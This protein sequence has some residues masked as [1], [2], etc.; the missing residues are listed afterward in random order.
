MANA[1]Q[2]NNAANKAS[3]K[4]LAEELSRG[5][6]SVFDEIMGPGYTAHQGVDTLTLGDV[7]AEYATLLHAFPDGSWT[8][9]FELAA[10]DETI[11][12]AGTFRGMQAAE[13]AGIGAA[14]Q[15]VA[16]PFIWIY[17]FSGGKIREGWVQR[18]TL[19]LVQQIGGRIVP[20]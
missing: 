14:G 15:H 20:S 3:V 16:I 7:K 13:F 5:N 10:E 19:A 1:Q 2:E 8:V 6:P 4:R 9:E 12:A 17:R 11:V 18:D